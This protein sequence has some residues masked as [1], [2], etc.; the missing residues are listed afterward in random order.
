MYVFMGATKPL[1][2]VICCRFKELPKKEST[3]IEK[4]NF[5]WTDHIYRH[6]FVHTTQANME[7]GLTQADF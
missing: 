5:E 6:L 3:A 2:R 1:A 4:A 7:A